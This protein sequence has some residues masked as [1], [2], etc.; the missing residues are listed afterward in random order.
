MTGYST[1]PERVC[2]SG[3]PKGSPLNRT[4]EVVEI[5]LINIMMNITLKNYNNSGYYRI[6]LRP[7]LDP[8][9]VPKL[10]QEIGQLQGIFRS[11]P[12]LVVVE[13]TEHIEIL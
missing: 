6:C 9:G 5:Q 8:F 7:G 13:V 2:N 12:Q 11:V 10:I 1:G 3:A 4:V